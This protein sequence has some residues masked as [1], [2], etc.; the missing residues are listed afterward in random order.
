MRER[1][2]QIRLACLIT[3]LICLVTPAVVQAQESPS[4]LQVA[5]YKA[6]PGKA[7]TFLDFLT[8]DA[9]KV[10]Q[11]GV[12]VGTFVSWT[13]SRTVIPRG[14]DAECDFTTV[15]TYQG[16]PECLGLNSQEAYSK[17]NL[18]QADI[19]ATVRSSASLVSV[20]LWRGVDRLGARFS[21]GDYYT[22]DLMDVPNIPDWIEVETKIY[23]PVHEERMKSGPIKGWSSYSLV[24]P[25]GAGRPF[26]AGTVNLLKDLK[27]LGG[28]AGYNAAFAKVHRDINRD[29][30]SERTQKSRTIVR[31]ML[32]QVIALA[33]A[34]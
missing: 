5:C 12:D 32:Q 7:A 17:A 11:A 28:P 15:R 13:A 34:R 4:F 9:Q 23:K 22:I 20:R 29:W 16:M 2:R 25:G 26:N 19:I 30:V 24:M 8:G 27:S 14:Q 1:T 33:E 6:L 3:G 10:A 31:R 21:E 18:K